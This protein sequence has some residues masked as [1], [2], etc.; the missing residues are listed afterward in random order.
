MIDPAAYV[1]CEL[2]GSIV[3]TTTDS[4]DATR[5]LSRDPARRCVVRNGAVLRWGADIK[6]GER[7]SAE[8]FLRRARLITGRASTSPEE[9]RA[10]IAH[11]DAKPDNVTPA[12]PA[13]EDNLPSTNISHETCRFEGCTSEIGMIRSDTRKEWQ[14]FCRKHRSTMRNLERN[15]S[16]AVKTKT[17]SK[18]PKPKPASKQ[19]TPTKPKKPTQREPRVVDIFDEMRRCVAV[20]DQLG[21][22]EKAEQLASVIGR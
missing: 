1:V 11:S 17:T 13:E 14:V 10:R 7:T 5:V 16:T 8:A 18:A 19:A 6:P 4:E 3:H 12:P 22:I 15:R 20:V 21:G 9:T 2:D